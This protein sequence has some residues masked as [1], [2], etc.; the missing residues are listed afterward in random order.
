MSTPTTP[1]TPR[2]LQVRVLEARA[3][4]PLIRLFRLAALEGEVLPGYTAGAHVRVRVKLGAIDEITLD[5]SG[6]VM[7]RLD[8]VTDAPTTPMEEDDGEA[9][10]AAGPISIAVDV[11]E[12][13]LEASSVVAAPA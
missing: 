9:D 5:I 6:T 1:A 13:A 4:N 2:P 10:M 3:L 11:S 7:E 8:T 12:P